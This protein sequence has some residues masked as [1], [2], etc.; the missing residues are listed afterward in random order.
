MT[1][2]GLPGSERVGRA[3]HRR[4]MQ[5]SSGQD[6]REKGWR[7]P[8]RNTWTGKGSAGAYCEAFDG[9]LA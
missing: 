2:A 4:G 7:P 5:S 3:H 8:E 6:R 9:Y 1:V